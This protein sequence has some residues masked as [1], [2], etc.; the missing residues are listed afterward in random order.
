[1]PA[2]TIHGDA[3][4]ID[5]RIS[6]GAA[7]EC[8]QVATVHDEGTR[9]TLVMVNEWLEAAK[10]PTIDYTEL[11][12]KLAGSRFDG[13]MASFDGWHATL[14]ERSKVN[15]MIAVLRRARDHSFGKD[16]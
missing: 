2:E 6:W 14:N 12:S 8:V 16:E 1:M 9:N 13:A 3:L 5:V 15:R 10:M 11:Q 4:P 7:L